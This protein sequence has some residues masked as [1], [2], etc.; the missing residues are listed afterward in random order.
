MPLYLCHG[1][2]ELGNIAPWAEFEPLS[3]A[4]LAGLLAIT[5][6][7]LNYITT[8]HAYVSYVVSLTEN[9]QYRIMHLHNA[10]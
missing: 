10:I 9:R 4:F 8:F 5:P 6:P 3:R 2:D 1:G 7:K